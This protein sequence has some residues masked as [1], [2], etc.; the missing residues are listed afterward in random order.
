[1]GHKRKLG[2]SDLPATS[3]P[4]SRDHP[5]TCSAGT[6]LPMH[7]TAHELAVE[8]FEAEQILRDEAF[9]KQIQ[10]EEA[11]V[12]AQTT[13]AGRSDVAI[14]AVLHDAATS[15]NSSQAIAAILQASVRLDELMWGD[16]N[17]HSIDQ[18]PGEREA[19]LARSP[20]PE[21]GNESGIPVPALGNP[22]REPESDPDSEPDAALDEDAPDPDRAKIIGALKAVIDML[23]GKTNSAEAVLAM[24]A[25][26]D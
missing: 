4:T 23:E 17:V 8:T 22:S 13:E 2:D 7:W 9:A 20:A 11:L 1:M 12:A 15:Q 24:Q 19:L 3:S 16:R 6:L 21:P 5:D 18:T 26:L 10:V 25:S 14:G